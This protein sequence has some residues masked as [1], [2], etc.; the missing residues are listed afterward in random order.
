MK[1]RNI[2]N[3]KECGVDLSPNANCCV[4]CGEDV[5]TIECPKCSTT[6]KETQ[7]F[8]LNC[9]WKVE[10][11]AFV[12]KTSPSN[13]TH[14]EVPADE[15]VGGLQHVPLDN[16][17]VSE[18]NK[19]RTETDNAFDKGKEDPIDETGD[20]YGNSQAGQTNS[21]SSEDSSS[22]NEENS[23]RTHVK[24]NTSALENRKPEADAS[25]VVAP[26]ATLVN[27]EGT[28]VHV[29]GRE[30]L[31]NT[32]HANKQQG[33][34]A[35]SNDLPPKDKPIS[36]KKTKRQ[37]KQEKKELRK[38]MK[39]RH[40][41]TASIDP[42][43]NRHLEDEIY[44][45]TEFSNSS[46]KTGEC[47]QIYFH[48]ILSPTILSNHN[49]DI[50]L[51]KIKGKS[52]ELKM[53]CKRVIGNGFAEYEGML[54]VE[55]GQ[56][57]S[58]VYNYYV[59]VGGK[60]DVDEFIYNQGHQE[61]ITRFIDLKKIAMKDIH[62]QFD[63]VVRGK[64]VQE[65]DKP[66]LTK[67]FK[68]LSA[69]MG[70]DAY[71]KILRDD[72]E[73]ALKNFLPKW[74]IS[75]ESGMNGIELI[76]RVQD[77]VRGMNNM[78]YST[79][80]LWSTW[81][82][83][84][85]HISKI[86][87]PYIELCISDLAKHR[88]HGRNLESIVI[89]IS[90]AATVVYLKEEY[91][92][93]LDDSSL[94]KLC[95]SMLPYIP[96]KKICCLVFK[97]ITNIFSGR[98]KE[99]CEFILKLVK[100]LLKAGQ[101][102]YLYCMPL[103]HYLQD[104]YQPFQEAPDDVNHHDKSAVW[105]GIEHF[106]ADLD[107]FKDKQKSLQKVIGSLLPFFEL[108][109]LLARTVVASMTF[110]DLTTLKDD[111]IIPIDIIMA[112]VYYFVNTFQTLNLDAMQGFKQ[113][114]TTVS[115]VLLKM[116]T[117]KLNSFDEAKR[118]Y[119]IGFDVL[120]LIFFSTKVDIQLRTRLWIAVSE[121]F[122][123]IAN[124]I[125]NSISTNE[126][127]LN[128]LKFDPIDM[129]E[130]FKKGLAY[131]LDVAQTDTWQDTEK[132][133]QLWDESFN[134]KIPDGKIKT[135]YLKHMQTG[136]RTCL[137][138]W[139]EP[140]KLKEIIDVYCSR[141]ESFHPALQEIL[142][143]CALE[144]VYVCIHDLP[145]SYQ[146][147]QGNQSKYYGALV[148]HVFE[149]NVN[150]NELKDKK[151]FLKHA[152][153]WPPFPVFVRM[154]KN[155]EFANSLHEKCLQ[156]M[157][158]CIKAMSD[159]CN[160]LLQGQITLDVLKILLS[161]KQNFIS[162]V[163]E[164]NAFATEFI[165]T[166]LCIREKELEAFTTTLAYVKEF[167]YVCRKIEGNTDDIE[168]ALT[169]FKQANEIPLEKVCRLKRAER[170]ETPTGDH[171]IPTYFFNN[172]EDIQQYQPFVTVLRFEAFDMD[173]IP[174]ILLYTKIYSFSQIWKKTGREV[175]KNK[176]KK[177]R[178]NEIILEVWKPS[179]T[180]WNSI[181]YKLKT[182]DLLF[183]EF[184]DYFYQ[185]ETEIAEILRKEIAYSSTRGDTQWIQIRLD[186]FQNHKM[187]FDCLKG[188]KAIM[189]IVHIY[190]LKGDFS[191]VNEIINMTDGEDAA[192]KTFDDSLVKACSILGRIDDKKIESLVMF[193]RCQPL[194]TWLKT[195][196][197]GLKE[198]NVFVDLAS[199]SAGE[200]D[201]E[202]DRAQVL[203]SAATGYAP[204]IFSLN[205]TCNDMEFIE[206]CETVWKEL[207]T[208]KKLP[209]KLK[210]TIQ[211]LDWFKSV[212]KSHGSIEISSLSQT[213]A[214]NS[215]GIYE[216]GN[217]DMNNHS[218]TPA[219]KEVLTLNVVQDV[220]SDDVESLR[221]NTRR[222]KYDQLLDLQSR[223]MLV[224]GKAEQGKDE[225]DRFML[226][227][228]AVAR[229]GNIYVKLVTDGCVLFNNWHATFLCDKN[230]P[231]CAFLHF[232]HGQSMLT[233]KGRTDKHTEDVSAMIPKL[234]KILEKFHFEWLDYIN[235]K[236]REYPLL[237]F[238][239]TDQIVI[240]QQQLVKM[241]TCVDPP[242]S[243][244]PLLSAVKKECSRDDLIAA[245]TAAKIHISALDSGS[246]LDEESKHAQVDEVENESIQEIIK[247]GF[248]RLLAKEAL[249]KCKS[250]EDAIDWCYDHDDTYTETDVI[251]SE[252]TQTSFMGW[253]DT[254]H[255]MATLTSSLVTEIDLKDQNESRKLKKALRKLW[256]K[257]LHSISSS[258]SDYLSIE[259]LGIILNKLNELDTFEVNRTMQTYLKE[260][261]P[262]LIICEQ[263]DLYN[264][265][266]S[267]YSHEFDQPLPQSDEVLLC[268]SET[269]LDTVD[270]F[271]RRSLYHT[272]NQIYCLVNVGQL[273]YEVSSRAEKVLQALLTD[274]EFIENPFRLV[275]ICSTENENHSVIS[276]ALAKY[277]RQQL[278]IHLNNVRSYVLTKL[279]S[280]STSPFDIK[281]ASC[282]D[283]DKCTVRVVRSSRAGVGKTLFKDRMK[284][285]MSK[286]LKLTPESRPHCLTI[287]LHEKKINIDDVVA[288]L[289]DEILPPHTRYP[290]I[291]HFDIAHEVH[292]GV[293]DFLFQLLILGC[294][295]HNSGYIWRKSH[296]DYYIIESMPLLSIV[297][298]TKGENYHSIHHCLDI[299]PSIVCCSPLESITILKGREKPKGFTERD[300]I[301]D[302]FEFEST[303]FQRPYQ[304]LKR[305]DSDSSLHDVKPCLT[306]GD[307]IHCLETLLRHCGI[308]DPSWAEL[309]HFVSFLDK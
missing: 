297:A 31:A 175:K 84:D 52:Q 178:I 262:N 261:E 205:E 60:H 88:G 100:A 18:A 271:L 189:A 107:Y 68:R 192:M 267:I 228:D 291:F 190:D 167:V 42:N 145:D 75:T 26:T 2:V 156:Y 174:Q 143:I 55:K 122:C 57:R 32:S 249:N 91:A 238:F 194:V 307:Q 303:T 1:C 7:K 47:V 176:G 285:E 250:V 184:E 187:I 154:C 243:I 102:F 82:D 21:S 185:E 27:I 124:W 237:N 125:F 142:S 141:V 110:Q 19:L 15:S 95:A 43:T 53:K 111:T 85:T 104:K 173:V 35:K 197:S 191:H 211:H 290:R 240:L 9:K 278:P 210:H 273:D 244:Y 232:G 67:V 90:T 44:R 56:P 118:A 86:L 209:K 279:T 146:E 25:Q 277:Q 77:I 247:C 83:F 180:F 34:E 144:A 29:T 66:L 183:T 45:R 79:V 71:L 170:I 200:T 120:N 193:A 106:K 39:E 65:K 257:F 96:N 140:Y 153:A 14:E 123:I 182:G 229:L 283:F 58:L 149:R 166:T 136:F 299:L 126:V 286:V 206:L 208:D 294:L 135:D 155:P 251:Q 264:T 69:W 287:P 138:K 22:E 59:K 74:Q 255:T 114:F 4:E 20:E 99:L 33:S 171:S 94:S 246:S 41:D 16:E 109:F 239:T 304:Y 226:I 160:E 301:F 129:F 302:R 36:T 70:S 274:A 242:P 269:S 158:V 227:F 89:D 263:C 113:L 230:R 233:V 188:A 28:D 236:R 202:V 309:Y 6:V 248:S 163:E 46:D 157:N 300:R 214:I 282:V 137:E 254:E 234:A 224:A 241:G 245:M 284:K 265:L 281:H 162:I 13:V 181:C 292:D 177:L 276:R 11:N 64:P 298:D 270:I 217:S 54:C 134:I 49:K 112:A 216:V 23:E 12:N 215:N 151:S 127:Q 179:Y 3:G 195:S 50:V 280:V 30:K 119:I 73:L 76:L 38:R 204:L 275:V 196:M 256:Q 115:S 201:I 198:L 93:K 169:D 80:K 305:L 213:K 296:I 5:R 103:L 78:Y 97:E 223:L 235:N 148:S 117:Q 253:F 17:D 132:W 231:A 152:M 131:E 40:K 220:D 199:M 172:F 161:G 24:T 186:Q 289:L 133:I 258:L 288:V 225:V 295:H 222:Y 207:E 306:E 63:G 308:K 128:E 218:R 165:E 159:A 101:V 260:G 87:K 268:G 219:L 266:L 130:K 164:I 147:Y 10:E 272:S 62:H 221:V 252:R 116:N 212:K 108:D 72:A 203:H 48:A 81:T 92:V 259:H 121:T 51:V 8:C 150:E 139:K 37:K 293:D 61:A 168:I 105:W 98:K